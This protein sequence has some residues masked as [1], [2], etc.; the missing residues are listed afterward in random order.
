VLLDKLDS[1]IALVEAQHGMHVP[2]RLCDVNISTWRSVAAKAGIQVVPFLGEIP[3]TKHQQLDMFAWD[4]RLERAQADRYIPYLQ[5]ALKLDE[6]MYTLVDAANHHP[7]L[8]SLTGRADE[9]GFDFS[10]TA[11][12]VI[13]LRQC[14]GPLLATG[15]RMVIN[16][17]KEN[18]SEG[19]P[20]AMISLVLANLYS[21][22]LK[23]IAVVTDL[24]EDHMFFWL[25]GHT[26]RFFAAESAGH[27]LGIIND[28]LAQEAVTD[29][30]E[31]E[32]VQ[33]RT[34]LKPTTTP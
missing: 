26:M 24:N 14:Q 16:L 27:A 22:G 21:A 34:L 10:G 11:D 9:L 4:D 2:K 23:P 12:V 15:L 18:A 6:R 13:A 3:Q 1:L 29:R 31:V 32:P 33:V 20:Q 8:L 17:K 7:C 30:A 25:D 19:Y 28:I 5:N